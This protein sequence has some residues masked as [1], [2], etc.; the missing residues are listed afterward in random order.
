[1]RYCDG[2]FCMNSEL[3]IDVKTALSTRA[4]CTGLAELSDWT[5]ASP[6]AF[7]DVPVV[8]GM[9]FCLEYWHL[10]SI[11]LF[12]V[13]LRK[14]AV[15]LLIVTFSIFPFL[16]TCSPNTSA[17][18]YCA[19]LKSLT[20]AWIKSKMH[21]KNKFWLRDRFYCKW[22]ENYLHEHVVENRIFFLSLN[23]A[24]GEQIPHGPAPSWMAA[25]L[26]FHVS[27][28]TLHAWLISW[29]TES[30]LFPLSLQE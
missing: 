22:L 13:T 24:L 3:C 20:S 30:P 7:L 5:T 27:L 14:M 23:R 29:L 4:H 10:Q 2:P 25:C 26:D 1:M 12:H 16:K 17:S 15:W 9:S 19:D 8:K 21:T 28:K 6:G 11:P 18:I